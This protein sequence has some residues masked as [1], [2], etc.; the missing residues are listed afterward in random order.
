MTAAGCKHEET[1]VR[2]GKRFCALC[3]IWCPTFSEFL[4]D[5]PESDE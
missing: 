4:G 1:V 5:A 3:G 2:D